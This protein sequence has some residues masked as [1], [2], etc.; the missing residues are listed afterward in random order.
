MFRAEASPDEDVAIR[1]SFVGV[2][3]SGD[4]FGREGN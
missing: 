1:H 2:R 4:A 3:T